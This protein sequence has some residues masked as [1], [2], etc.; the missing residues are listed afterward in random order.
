MIVPLL[1][2][3]IRSNACRV[4]WST[5]SNLYLIYLS[6][7]SY[8]YSFPTLRLKLRLPSCFIISSSKR[9]LSANGTPSQKRMVSD[10]KVSRY[11]GKSSLKGGL[12]TM[13]SNLRKT[14]CSPCGMVPLMYYLVLH[15]AKM[16]QSCWESSSDE[17]SLRIFQKRVGTPLRNSCL[18]YSQLF[19]KPFI[20]LFLFD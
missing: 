6:A 12:L 4:L 11:S 2:S 10:A 9:W 15:L 8:F 14:R 18:V 16:R 1:S 3:S 13:K 5:A 20:G 19:C 7:Y 17:A